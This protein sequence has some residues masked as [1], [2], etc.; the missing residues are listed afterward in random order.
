[1]LFEFLFVS[2]LCV[3]VNLSCVQV[4]L[5]R[6]RVVG[7]GATIISKFPLLHEKKEGLNWI[8]FTVENTVQIRREIQPNQIVIC[9]SLICN[10]L[11]LILVDC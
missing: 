8:G 2:F 5:L 7:E 3:F 6:Y 4:N 11:K 1:M 10:F 9:I